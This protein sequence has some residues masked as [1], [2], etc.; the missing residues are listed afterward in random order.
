MLF[1]KPR[2]EIQHFACLYLHIFHWKCWRKTQD[3]VVCFCFH[4]LKCQ[5]AL[6]GSINLTAF[7][8]INYPWT[9][10][11][12]P[13]LLPLPPADDPAPHFTEKMEAIRRGHPLATITRLQPAH[14]SQRQCP[15]SYM[16]THLCSQRHPH[17]PT[18]RCPSS[19]CLLS[20]LPQLFSVCRRWASWS[21]WASSLAGVWQPPQE[22]RDIRSSFCPQ[23]VVPYPKSLHSWP[24]FFSHET[25]KNPLSN[26]FSGFLRLTA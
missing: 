10:L 26:Y 17:S 11:R 19:N 15:D 24:N 8:H 21:L 3:H 7:P 14:G 16:I 22:R 18:Q 2:S 13:T 5:G 4:D 9:V 23:W 25:K 1:Q 20:L 12:L 6:E